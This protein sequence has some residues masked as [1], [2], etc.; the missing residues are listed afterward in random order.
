MQNNY[1]KKNI[2]RRVY[3]VYILKTVARPLIIELA[4]VSA[5]IMSVAF[6]V[7]LQNVLQNALSVT[8]IVDFGKFIIGAFTHTQ[9]IVQALSLL[10]LAG[11]S[12]MVYDTVRRIRNIFI[13]NYQ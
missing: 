2:M 10:V 4:I 6:F 9:V 8:N 13:F 11:A 12:A 5:L 3:M 1:I 7:S